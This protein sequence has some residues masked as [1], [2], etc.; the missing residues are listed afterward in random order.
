MTTA[1]EPADFCDDIEYL[2]GFLHDTRRTLADLVH[3]YGLLDVGRLRVDTLGDPLAPAE[4]LSAVGAALGRLG[5][6][7]DTAETA[8]DEARRSASRLA[9]VGMSGAERAA[10]AEQEWV[11][12]ENR[13]RKLAASAKDEEERQ[14]ALIDGLP[15]PFSDLPDL[16]DDDFPSLPD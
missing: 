14:W 4:A 9:L 10:Q 1:Y 15:D 3:D 12:K 8:L 11:P 7:F 5:A 16:P 2:G 13:R 6:A